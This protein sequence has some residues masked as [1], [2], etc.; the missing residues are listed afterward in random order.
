MMLVQV[1]GCNNATTSITDIAGRTISVTDAANATTT[2]VYDAL[3]DLPAVVT[4]AMGHTS[5]Y[6]Y[7]ALGRPP[8]RDTARKG[9]IV[10]DTFAHNA[11][12]ELVEAT[13]SGKNYEYAYDN[14]GNNAL[15]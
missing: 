7:D 9:T 4:D 3:H 11:R 8:A 5:C 1:D 6:K 12:C 15:E 2:T 14:I 13:V 10:N